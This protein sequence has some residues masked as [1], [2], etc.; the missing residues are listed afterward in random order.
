MCIRDR[1]YWLSG[2]GPCLP[3]QR[4]IFRAP[5]PHYHTVP[6][7]GRSCLTNLISPYDPVTR[8]ADE[9]KA[10]GVLCLDFSKAFR[11]VSHGVLL[12]KL[13]PTARI[14]ALCAG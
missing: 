7:K 13:Q 6:V 1:R 2:G 9:G 11:T 14:G 12:G 4:D 3:V 5:D 10:V 8:L